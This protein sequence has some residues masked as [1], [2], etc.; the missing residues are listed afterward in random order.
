MISL[1]AN[2]PLPLPVRERRVV[3]MT[4]PPRPP[5]PSARRPER[6]T[7]TLMPTLV[8]TTLPR[9]RNESIESSSLTDIYKGLVRLRDLDIY[10][11]KRFPIIS[12]LHLFSF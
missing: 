2:S 1:K 7:P 5:L 6:A 10:L 12:V 3:L 11:T 9:R 4:A 8:P